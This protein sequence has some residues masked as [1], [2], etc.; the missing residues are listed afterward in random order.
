MF[1]NDCSIELTFHY[2]YFIFDYSWFIKLHLNRYELILF[3][4]FII[5][6]LLFFVEEL[7]VEYILGM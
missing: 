3:L 7:Y 1:S 2:F 4:Q 6:Q 5:R